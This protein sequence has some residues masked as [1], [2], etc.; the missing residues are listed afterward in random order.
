MPCIGLCYLQRVVGAELPPL[1]HHQSHH[2]GHSDLGVLGCDE[3]SGEVRAKERQRLSLGHSTG[4]RQKVDVC[5]FQGYSIFNITSICSE[6]QMWGLLSS[7]FLRLL[8]VSVRGRSRGSFRLVV[9]SSVTHRYEV[10]FSPDPQKLRYSSEVV[11]K[12]ATVETEGESR[13]HEM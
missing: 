2:P 12:C 8:L 13:K 4:S 7:V 5:G 1:G 6:K 9:A 11:R 10:T 3:G